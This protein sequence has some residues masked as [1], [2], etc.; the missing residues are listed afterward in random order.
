MLEI[1]GLSSRYDAITALSTV[2]LSIQRG[3]I[4]SLLGANGAGKSTL[5]G[6]I[7]ASISAEVSGSIRF[8]GQEIVGKRTE[9][10][11]ASGI[12]LVPEGRQLFGQLTVEE[13]VR[14]GAYLQ[15]DKRNMVGDL[16][17][18]Y[19]LFPQLVERRKQLAATLSGGEQQMVAIGRALMSRPKL[20]LMDEPSLGLA[21]LMVS[22]IIR[23]IQ[24]INQH[25]VTV[26]LVEQNARQ[27]LKI[28]T[29]AYVLEKGRMVMSGDASELASDPHVVSAYLGR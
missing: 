2:D 29:R 1:T 23:L 16:H 14:M 28:S 15:H 18:V 21:P 7:T 25:G 10:I 17:L 5:L 22:A 24:Q 8:E 26:L 9:Q 11:V 4:V 20:L 19:Q 27:A 12:A 6:A 3:Q 13:N